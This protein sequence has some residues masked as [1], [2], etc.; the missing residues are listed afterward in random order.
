M[1]PKEAGGYVVAS[2]GVEPSENLTG[3]RSWPSRDGGTD[4]LGLRDDLR[5]PVRLRIRGAH[6]KKAIDQRGGRSDRRSRNTNFSD[7]KFFL[8]KGWR[9]GSSKGGKERRIED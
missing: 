9:K 3:L 7:S 8:R 4:G 5:A 6:R 1:S 2:E